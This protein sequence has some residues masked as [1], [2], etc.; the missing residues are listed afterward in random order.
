M[1]TKRKA[2]A[3]K[4]AKNKAT[5]AAGKPDETVAPASETGAVAEGV[6]VQIE[7]LA[8]PE[9]EKVKIGSMICGAGAQAVMSESE[10]DVGVDKGWWKITGLGQKARLSQPGAIAHFY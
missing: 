3:K 8:Q 6:Q 5:Q 7:V 9:G 10:A 1:S 4:T 2:A